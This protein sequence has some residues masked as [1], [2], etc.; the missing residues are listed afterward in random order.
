MG[1][2]QP[3]EPVEATLAELDALPDDGQR[4]ELIDGFLA[5]TPAP[6][7]IHQR[8]VMRLIRMLDRACPDDLE[9]FTAP[10]DFRPG[11][12]RS[13]QP[14][15]LICRP[16][17]V[18]PKAIE[19]T[20]A[21]TVEVLSPS[22]RFLDLYV[23]RR[24]Y[25]EAGVP[26]YWIIDPERPSLTVLELDGTHYVERHVVKA[27]DVVTVHRPFPVRIMPAKLVP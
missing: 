17:D 15:L 24:A 1:L 19:G 22:S 7:T 12:P 10:T 25:A 13:F 9:L 26:A 23:K 21:L 20:P 18:G 4:Y 3:L 8:A 11:G 16:A 5:V 27:S 6:L 14:D 2:V